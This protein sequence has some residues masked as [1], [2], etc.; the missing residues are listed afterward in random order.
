[1]L[2][3]SDLMRDI[4][5]TPKAVSSLGARHV[6]EADTSEGWWNIP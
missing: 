5:D 2:M 6:E 3:V 1:M 4:P